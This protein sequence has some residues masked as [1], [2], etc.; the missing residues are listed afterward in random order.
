MS[1]RLRSCMAVVMA[2]FFA[3]A[4]MVVPKTAWAADID[5]VLYEDNELGIN[6]RFD[7]NDGAI[8][9]NVTVSVYVEGELKSTTDLKGVRQ[10]DS[11]VYIT[12]EGYDVYSEIDGGATATYIEGGDYINVNLGGGDTYNLDISLAKDKI[13]NDTVIAKNANEYG[14]FS[15]VNSNNVNC[16]FIRQL[17]VYVDDEEVAKTTIAT[18]ENLS[19]S[20]VFANHQYWFTPNT[21]KHKTTNVRLEPATTLS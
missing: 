7:A 19:N 12:A 11:R 4:V 5:Q 1:K 8:K 2:A 13:S 18:P 17:T 9:K 21:L 14:T 20:E 16:A 10:V 15:W 3:L 6:V